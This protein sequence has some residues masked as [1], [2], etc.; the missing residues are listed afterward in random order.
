M[1]KYE[2]PSNKV[3]R[4]K[5]TELQYRVTQDSATER[6]YYNQFWNTFDK[7]LY[8]DV[9]TGEPLF[10]SD[11]KFESECGWP[12]FSKPVDEAIVEKNDHSF[13]MIRTE[14]RSKIGDS[15]LGHVFRGEPGTPNG[16]RY[17]INSA[18]LRFI[19]YESLE[20]EG[21]GDLL[22]LFR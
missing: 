3:L 7:G 19:P 1:I 9:V 16:V 2:K 6:P 4:E 11:D 13:G 17:C 12:A 20:E 10:I 21:Y 5:L 15:H 8:V 18:S 14:V 22:K